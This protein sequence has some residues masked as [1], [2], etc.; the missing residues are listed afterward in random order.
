MELQ[1]TASD[2]VHEAATCNEQG[3]IRG[4]V[5]M[6][7]GISER[8]SYWGMGS[9][10]QTREPV[11]RRITCTLPVEPFGGNLYKVGV[12]SRDRI[13]SAA[14]LWRV[15]Y[16]ELSGSPREFLMSTQNPSSVTHAKAGGG[17]RLWSYV[18]I[19]AFAGMMNCMGSISDTLSCVVVLSG[20][21]NAVKITSALEP[22]I[23]CQGLDNEPSRRAS[24]NPSTRSP[25]T[26]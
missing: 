19:P 17:Q 6:K 11:E 1:A 20:G 15:A 16:P 10:C 14:E 21:R 9:S 23:N 24:S 2:M 18:W 13:E 7:M 8:Q 4:A 3:F 26:P 25:E 5:A 12:L 22:L